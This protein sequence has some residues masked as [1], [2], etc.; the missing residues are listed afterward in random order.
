MQANRRESGVERRLRRRLWSAGV[1]GYRLRSRLPGRPD[2]A[3][4]GARLAVFVNGCY[5]HRCPTCNLP[6]PRANAAFWEEKL[7]RNQDRDISSA[8]A[9]A[10]M[11]WLAVTI[12]EHEVRTDLDAVIERLTAS[13]RGHRI[14][15]HGPSVSADL[16]RT[17]PG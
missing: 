14:H 12:W 3:F 17:R 6:T 10:E 8:A 9:L 15:R 13:I 16:L 4:P 11:G 5:W 2:L 7:R 1:R